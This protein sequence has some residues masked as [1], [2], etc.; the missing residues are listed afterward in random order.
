MHLRWCLLL[1]LVGLFILP[2][3]LLIS[4]R[5]NRDELGSI[6]ARASTTPLPAPEPEPENPAPR[7]PQAPALPPRAPAQRTAVNRPGQLSGK[8]VFPSPSRE[9]REFSYKIYLFDEEGK[10]EKPRTISNSDRFEIHDLRPGRKGVLF[11]SPSE[12]LTCPYQIVTVPEGGVCETILQPAIA[13]PLRGQVVDANGSP[14]GGVTVKAVETLP[15]PG[16]LYLRGTPPT[17]AA[18]TSPFT[19]EHFT[20]RGTTNSAEVRTGT[21]QIDPGRGQIARSVL[22]DSQG[23]FALLISSETLP[24]PLSVFRS[25]KEVLIEETVLP[26]AGAVRIMVPVQ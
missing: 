17:D 21:I 9:R 14:V 4:A 11:F 19:F 24:V 1:L 22:T 3:I 5:K 7:Q 15:L 23:R 26:S 10:N 16:E 20:K 2:W 18:V 8:V 25:P 6:P 12:K 13:V